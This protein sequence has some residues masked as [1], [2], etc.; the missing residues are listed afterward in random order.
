MLESVNYNFT[1]N[2]GIY[3]YNQPVDSSPAL[4]YTGGPC[5][6]LHEDWLS[7]LWLVVMFNSCRQTMGYSF[8]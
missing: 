2:T 4:L 8:H 7:W 6:N 5:W 1:I 3:L